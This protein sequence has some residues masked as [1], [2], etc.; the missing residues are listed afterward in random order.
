MSYIAH[1]IKF[2]LDL[3]TLFYIKYGQRVKTKVIDAPN[4]IAKP[5]TG[6]AIKM[7]GRKLG[8]PMKGN[9]RQLFQLPSPRFSCRQRPHP[10]CPPSAGAW[11]RRAP[12]CAGLVCCARA[13]AR[14]A[15]RAFRRPL[16]SAPHKTP[17]G[18]RSADRQGPW[19]TI[20][21]QNAN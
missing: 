3:N 13:C 4:L 16:S 21:H 1:E 20:C 18:L 10:S 14:G 8:P 12:G 6:Q 2:K 11:N 9:T 19:N 5:T 17:G 15:S 7:S